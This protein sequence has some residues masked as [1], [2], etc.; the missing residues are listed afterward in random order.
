MITWLSWLALALVF[1][2]LWLMGS[3]HYRAGWWFALAA[4][5]TWTVWCVATGSWALAAQQ[6]MIAVLSVRALR[7]LN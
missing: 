6:G 4:C 5:A 1:A 2:Q 3:K 7:N